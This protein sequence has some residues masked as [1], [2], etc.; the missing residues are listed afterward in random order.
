MLSDTVNSLSFYSV[1]QF[2]S[3]KRVLRDNAQKFLFIKFILL[4]Y[5]IK[6]V[7]MHFLGVVKLYANHILY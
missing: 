6:L 2:D 5:F 4:Q 1:E 7:C 3:S